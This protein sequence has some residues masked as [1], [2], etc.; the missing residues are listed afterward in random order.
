MPPLGYLW[1]IRAG[2]TGHPPVRLTS[3]LAKLVLTMGTV[4]PF[5]NLM[6]ASMSVSLMNACVTQTAA[7]LKSTRLEHLDV[8]LAENPVIRLHWAVPG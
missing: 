7:H 2:P 4:L 3:R 1:S 6:N 5:F 8:S